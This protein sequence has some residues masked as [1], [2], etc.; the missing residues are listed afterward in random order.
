MKKTILILLL[1]IAAFTAKAQ[2]MTFEETVKYINDK[3][4]VCKYPKTFTAQ[5]DGT[6]KAGEKSY[7]L[8]NFYE[9]PIENKNNIKQDKGIAYC[10]DSDY[11]YIKLI[12]NSKGEYEIFAFFATE[13]ETERV[14]NALVYLRGLCTKNKDPFD[15]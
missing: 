7:N 15:K 4:A 14:Y 12:M 10:V 13:K 2:N 6:I 1:S 9:T 11:Q 3:L 8:F 5:K